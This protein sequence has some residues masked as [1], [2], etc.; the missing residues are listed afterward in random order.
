MKE[1]ILIIYTT[2]YKKGGAQFEQVANTLVDEKRK[3]N[4]NVKVVKVNSKQEVIALFNKVDRQP[5]R[6]KEFYFIGHSGMYGP[7]FGTEAFP[8][9][10]SPYELKALKIPFAKDASASFYACRTARW[11]APYFARV[12]NIDT[13]GYHW[14]TTFSSQKDRFSHPS[15]STNFNTLY[16]FGS[17]G[18]KSHGI[19]TSIK[20]RLGFI[21]P[22]QLKKFVPPVNETDT[23]YNKVAELYA[24]TFNDIKVRKDEFNWITKHFSQSNEVNMLDIGCGNGALLKEFAPQISKGVGVDTS[25]QLLKFAKELNLQNKHI[26]FIQVDAP[27]LPF[28][29]ESFDVV[30]SL[31]S[32]RYLDWDFMIEEINRV[33]KKNGKLI[34][35]DMVTAPLKFKELP[36]F[37]KG[38][39]THYLD[40]KR[41][42]NFYRNLQKLVTHKDWAQM[43]HYNPIRSQQEMANYLTSRYPNGNIKVI[44][45]GLH[46]RVIAFE[47][48]VNLT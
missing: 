35:I 12:Q 11:F 8:E 25:E 7:M 17:P 13:Y 32:F 30:V 14:Y 1:L 48:T 4:A 39:L 38:K 2:T 15:L 9:Q 3:S 6:I 22:E 31:L 41:H 28:D 47:V 16:L 10:F 20:K 23:T 19:I 42:P 34:I 46:S 36:S 24:N 40:R 45:I 21:K 5:A 33:L 26:E 18:L 37:I 29:T 27:K 43:L 44:N